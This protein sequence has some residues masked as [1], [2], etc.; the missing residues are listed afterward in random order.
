MCMQCAFEASKAA[1]STGGAAGVPGLLAAGAGALGLSK[2][3]RWLQSRGYRFL[4]PK[5]L[6]IATGT[7]VSISLLAFY[8]VR[9]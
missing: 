9:F 6:R 5:R 4:T 1:A 3:S 2:L 7:I 8:G